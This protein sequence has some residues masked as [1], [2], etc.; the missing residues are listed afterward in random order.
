MVPPAAA[1]IVTFSTLVNTG[2]RVAAEVVM[3]TES[4][5]SPP[6]MVSKVV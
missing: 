3:D 2:V 4:V 1:V 5:P 6:S